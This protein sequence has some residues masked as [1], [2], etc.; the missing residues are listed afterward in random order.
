MQAGHNERPRLRFS[1]ISIARCAGPGPLLRVSSGALSYCQSIPARER[2]PPAKVPRARDLWPPA[3]AARRAGCG[4]W[5]RRLARTRAAD[6]QLRRGPGRRGTS[7]TLSRLTGRS[8][9]SHAVCRNRCASGMGE[10]AGEPGDEA[11]DGHG[12]EAAHHGRVQPGSHLGGQPV[13]PRYREHH[14]LLPGGRKCQVG[15]QR[16]EQAAAGPGRLPAQ[17]QP[18]TPVRFHQNC[19]LDPGQPGQ[20]CRESRRLHQAGDPCAVGVLGGGQ[21]HA[22]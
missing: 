3:L 16:R 11:A 2:T 10:G 17:L 12:G 9:R 15:I 7:M 21:Q 14:G 19:G 1:R 6:G 18:G 4:R 13:D 22:V 20:R 5:N 8:F